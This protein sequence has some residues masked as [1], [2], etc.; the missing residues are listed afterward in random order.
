MNK[1]GQTLILFVIMIPIL[2]GLCAFVI[3][4]G[5]IVLANTKL[6]EV[7]KTIIS[8]VMDDAS[9]DK[10]QSLYLKNDIPVENLEVEIKE[11]Q[12]RVQNHTI[13]LLKMNNKC[14]DSKQKNY[15]TKQN[16]NS[17][18]VCSIFIISCI[19]WDKTLI[20]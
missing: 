19:N 2:L 3:D 12:I 16:F 13:K 1:N 15:K 8:D 10:I 9:I 18:I 20:F 5:S 11:D 7:T 14:N 6:R 17:N 4:V